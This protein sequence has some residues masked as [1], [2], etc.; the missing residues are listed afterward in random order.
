[1]VTSE[2]N[3]PGPSWYKF[4]LP[5]WSLVSISEITM[6]LKSGSASCSCSEQGFSKSGNE[7]LL[8]CNPGVCMN[9][10]VLLWLS[11]EC[12]GAD[13]LMSSSIGPTSSSSFKPPVG[14]CFFFTLNTTFFCFWLFWLFW[15]VTSSSIVIWLSTIT[16]SHY[17]TFP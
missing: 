2:A 10:Q 12:W 8:F 6:G 13:R 5:L 17:S 4:L 7:P 11:C 14:C 9:T 3:L 1:M 15:L 16:T